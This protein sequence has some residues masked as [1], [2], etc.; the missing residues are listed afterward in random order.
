VVSGKLMRGNLVLLSSFKESRDALNIAAAL[1]LCHSM[2]LIHDDIIDMDLL[3]RGHPAIHALYMKDVRIRSTVR[4]HYGVSQGICLGDIGFFIA[5]SLLSELSHPKAETIRTFFMQEMM[6]VGFGEMQDVY[7]GLTDQ[8]PQATD[9]LSMYTAKTARYSISL[10]IALGMYLRGLPERFIKP[11]IT[12]GEYLGTAFQLKD[13][14]LGLFGD[15]TATGKGVWKDVEQNKKTILRH[16]LFTSS[17]RAEQ[18]RLKKIFGHPILAS[19][20]REFVLS[21]CQKYKVRDTAREMSQDLLRKAEK[22]MKKIPKEYQ[23][24]FEFIIDFNNTRIK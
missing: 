18:A 16:L 24:I 3:R 10:P 4:S 7:F 1:E 19:E 14:E 12:I 2:L 17:T 6:R 11:C 8:E 20:D 22:S 13:D 9:I 15:S 23:E 21:L 5:F